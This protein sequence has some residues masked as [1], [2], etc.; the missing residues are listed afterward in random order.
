MRSAVSRSLRRPDAARR[1]PWPVVVCGAFHPTGRPDGSTFTHIPVKP[2]GN[3]LRAFSFSG[4][5]RHAHADGR[6]PPVRRD[7]RRVH[8]RRRSWP[9]RSAGSRAASW[10]VS[11][12]FGMEGCALIDMVARHGVPVPVIYLDTMFLFPETYALRDRM[13][14]RYPHLRFE[15]RGTTLTPEAQAERFGPELWRRD[16][17]RCCALRKVEPMRRRWPAWMSGSPGSCG[18]RAASAPALRVARVGLELR[19]APG[20][21]AGR[22]GPAP[23]V[24]LRARARRALQR[25]ARAGLS[26]ARLHPL[27]RAGGRAPGPR[28]YTRSGRWAGTDKTECGLH[29]GPTRTL[30]SKG[31]MHR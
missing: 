29:V 4:L 11:T 13:V 14:A 18:A 5:E 25:A 17:D 27:H 3:V 26:H 8:A 21:P 10:C 1:A 31:V 9:G 6:A 7:R 19:A 24:G 30:R 22:L 12:S 23:G 20:E 16:P 2:A 28:D 15:N